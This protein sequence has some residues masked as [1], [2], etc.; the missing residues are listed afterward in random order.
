MDETM[1]ATALI[2]DDDEA[3][4]GMIRRAIESF[5]RVVA[6][7]ES[8]EEALAAALEL[9]PDVVLVAFDLPESGGIATTHRIK[10]ERPGTRVVLMTAH[11]EE[12]YLGGTGRSGADALLPKR[13]VRTEA[14]AVLGSVLRNRRR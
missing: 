8:D 1:P 9:G 7:A 5:V 13:A 12:A 11:G 3:A 2:A 6:E 4:R 14:R 10:D